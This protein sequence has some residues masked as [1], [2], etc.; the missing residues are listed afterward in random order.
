MLMP[1]RDIEQLRA[2]VGK[3]EV[4]RDAIAVFPAHA[5]AATLDHS[6]SPVCGDDLP[7]PWHWLYFLPTPLASSTGIDGHPAH[8]GFLPPVT[9][10]RRM[11]AAGKLEISR[12]LVIGE[13]A[14]KRS[15][16]QSVDLKEGRSGTLV[17]V[18]VLHEFTQRGEV[19]ITEE[20]NLV[21][22]D[23]PAEPSTLP[24]GSRPERKAQFS[25]EIVP[26]PVLLFRYSALT[27]NGH[28]IHYDR[29][30]A[31]NDEF[32]PALVVHGP[33]LATLLMDL[34]VAEFPAAQF[35]HF[36]FR[37]V[38]PTFDDHPFQLQGRQ[39]EGSLELW[40]VDHNGYVG[41]TATAILQ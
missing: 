22:R 7:I 20:Q 31:V 11:W 24:P 1:D 14:N 3:Q 2:W 37:A 8:G 6:A 13:Q 33:L 23:M 9:L 4:R 41:M 16:I 25:R 32:Y 40:T 5:L 19:C 39:N 27:F 34:A 36:Q 18:N 38:R 21:Y 29:D 15:T 30:F 12:P 35:Q 17:F 10:P 28:R 26:D